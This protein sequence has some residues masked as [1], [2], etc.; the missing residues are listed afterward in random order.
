MTATARTS[1]PDPAARPTLAST[2]DPRAN[3]LAV[4]RLLL[5]TTVALVHA[6]ELARGWRPEIASTEIGAV[7][8]DGFFVVSGFLV[9]ASFVRLGS[10][11][12]YAWHRA[13]RILPAF[14][15]C[16]VLTT[17]V[18]A[19][20]ISALQGAG[21]L[22]VYRGEGSALDYLVHNAGLMIRQFTIDTLPPT[23]PGGGNVNGA[24]WTLFYEALCYGLV[25]V[26][27]LLAVLRR[28]RWL[29]LAALAV[30]Q[31]ALL[32]QEL[33]LFT[34]PVENLPRLVFVFLLGAAAHLWADRI[35]I[36]RPL[37]LLALATF[38]A[39]VLLL[40]DY[41]AVGG[42]A[43]GYVVVHAVVRL[44]LRQEPAYDLSYGT[45]IFHWPLSV[46]ALSAGVGVLPLPLVLLVC[47]G[48]TGVAALLSWRLVEAPA[49]R[50]KS[51]TWVTRPLPGRER[52]RA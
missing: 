40:E 52:Q 14:Y 22:A 34:L 33:G 15:V 16:L 39:S 28:R 4:L 42:V 37:L 6:T 12:R 46:L 29:V 48:T 26:L 41:R 44:P 36:S 17:F 21:P 23:T 47:L 31:A 9:T 18:L 5:A 49:L 51:A 13:L 8:V 50:L 11:R 20:A 30:L 7:A 2:F 43:F 3:S 24:L 35:R 32:A 45:Y 25:A 1:P 38:V 10:L 19:P 27:G